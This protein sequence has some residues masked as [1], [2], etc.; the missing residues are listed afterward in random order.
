[1][2]RL[3]RIVAIASL[4]AVV[5]TACAPIAPIKNS[6]LSTPKLV[7]NGVVLD[8]MFVRT[9]LGG[10]DLNEGVWSEIDELHFSPADRRRF[11]SNGL[12]AGIISGPLPQPIERLLDLKELPSPEGEE[13]KEVDEER[14]TARQRQLRV[15]PGKRSEII[16][17]GEGDRIPEM[18]LLMKDDSGQVKGRTL[19]NVM[20]MFAAR[21]YPQ[22]DGGVRLE[23]VPELEHGAA[24]K[25]F[26]PG[27]GMFRVEFGP[28]HEVLEELRIAASLAPGQML[29]I[30]ARPDRVGSLGYRFFTETQGDATMQKM[31][32]I[33]LAHSEFD[34]RFSDGPAMATDE[35]GLK[36]LDLKALVHETR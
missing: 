8:V 32:V 30:T 16:A 3:T 36:R 7:K 20:G 6:V 24:Q 15:R 28:P 31:I 13:P 25:R 33:R 19:T 34:E 9:S 22:G 2:D 4:G 14:H 17:M 10:A 35:E 5:F 11:E 1:M 27:D 26:V 23:L 21:A 18:S 29:A 12:R